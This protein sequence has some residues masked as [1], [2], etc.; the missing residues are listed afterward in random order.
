MI[1]WIKQLAQK[2]QNAQKEEAPAETAVTRETNTPNTQ[3]IIELASVLSDNDTG[4]IELLSLYAEDQTI[5]FKARFKSILDEDQQ[6]ELE[7]VYFE[8]IENIVQEGLICLGYMGANDWKFP[9]EDMLFNLQKAFEHYGLDISVYD[10]IPNKGELC[11]PG[12]LQLITER[13]PSDFGLGMWDF[14]EDSWILIVAP[15]AN[16]LLAEKLGKELGFPIYSSCIDYCNEFN[17]T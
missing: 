13:L 8:D 5:D 9:L 12:A 2:T 11:A 7:G 6:E 15:K 1:K 16:L 17:I 10:D 3:K 4:F 14:G